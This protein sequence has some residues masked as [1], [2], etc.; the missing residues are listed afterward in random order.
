MTNRLI[1]S[2]IALAIAAPAAQASNLISNGD[3]SQFAAGPGAG[4]TFR[5]SNN[6]YVAWTQNVIPNAN[7][8]LILTLASSALDST[9]SINDGGASYSLWNTTTTPAG[10]NVI[11]APP[12]GAAT[13]FAQDSAAENASYLSQTISGLTVGGVYSVTFNWAGAQLESSNGSSW[14]GATNEAVEV[15]LGG[16]YVGG[17][18]QSFTGGQTLFATAGGAFSGSAAQAEA[19]GIQV[20]EHGF[21]GWNSA[22]LNF[23]ATAANEVLNL[24]AISSSSGS[25][26][27]ALI[28][29][30]QLNA[31]PEPSA[32]TLMLIGVAGLGA[33]F[34]RRRWTLTAA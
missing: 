14:N 20:P 33:A 12:S 27:F 16:T 24:E 6:Q 23:T 19:N 28:D 15:N 22:T 2:A 18:S 11:T 21:V 1:A 3:F 10:P 30:V 25:P 31:I 5:S 4:Y 9:A 7:G 8:G 29:N 26:P 17:L 32:W 34:R 13:V